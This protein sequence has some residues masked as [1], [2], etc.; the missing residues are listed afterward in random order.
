MFL[1]ELDNKYKIIHTSK[2]REIDE[3][4]NCYLIDLIYKDIKYNNEKY[5]KFFICNHFNLN[6]Y[7]SST[8]QF[9]KKNNIL[10]N[11]IY[12][13]RLLVTKNGDI[14]G[15]N[16]FNLYKYNFENDNF[17]SDE[18]CLGRKTF[19]SVLN[20]VEKNEKKK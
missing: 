18:V 15:N 3:I 6:L 4:N 14:Y 2:I 9:I 10:L 20:I 5:N 17:I 16:G 19:I 7:S 1:C 8:L 12:I 11:N 13:K